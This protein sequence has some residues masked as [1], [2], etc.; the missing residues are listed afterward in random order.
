[1][2]K[3]GFKMPGNIQ[4]LMQQAQRLKAD[5]EKVQEESKSLTAESS[6]GGGVINVVVNG[7]NE[8]VS[9]KISPEAVNPADT[10]MLQ[11]M[12]VAAVNQAF[13][14][15]HEEADARVKKVTGGMSIPGF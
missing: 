12:I 7:R 3:G 9:L 6:T 4:G 2:S 13:K 10:E 15:V 5:L 1:M 14:K 8:I 11:D